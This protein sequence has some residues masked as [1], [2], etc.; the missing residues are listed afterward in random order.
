MLE[1]IWPKIVEQ[2]ERAGKTID[3]IIVGDGPYRAQMES[4]LANWHAHFLG[5]R[6]GTEL[7][8]IYASS[9]LFIF[10]STTDTLG[11]VVMESQ[12]SGLPVIVTDQG[13][14]KEIVEDQRTGYVLGAHA[15]QRWVDTIVELAIDDTKRSAMGNAGIQAMNEYTFARSFEH[16][17]DVHERSLV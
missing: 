17:W 2:V 4:N 9:D 12:A 8:R 7:A 10:P 15:H 1:A 3:L 5:F 16:Y 11:Q 6:H 13:G 14:P